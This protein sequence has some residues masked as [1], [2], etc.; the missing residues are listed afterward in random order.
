MFAS[1]QDKADGS[2]G[3]TLKDLRGAL[4]VPL[5]V[6]DGWFGVVG[7]F[8]W[9][10]DEA[11]HSALM[12]E[13]NLLDDHCLNDLGVRRPFDQRTDDLVKRLRAGG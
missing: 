11:Q 7:I 3:Q 13:L 6:I 5:A 4:P 8:R 10:R 12:H 1:N 2:P 9:L